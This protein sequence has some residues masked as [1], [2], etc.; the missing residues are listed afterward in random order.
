[1]GVKACLRRL[2]KKWPFLHRL[3]V[4]AYFALRPVRLRELVI[5]TRAREEEWARRHLRGGNDWGN[6]QRA[7]S[8]DEWVMSYWDSRDHAHR[9]FLLGRLSAFHPFSS[10]LEIGCNCGPNLYLVA[11]RF[12][13]AQVWGVDI[14][15]AAVETGTRL[16]ASEGISNVKLSVGRAD[17]LGQFEDNQVDVVFTDAVLIYVGP[18]KIEQVA[19]EMVRVARRGIILVEQHCFGSNWRDRKGLG[20]HNGDVWVRDYSALFQRLAIEAPVR[21]T[22][23]PE[24]AWP[25]GGWR[26]GGIGRSCCSET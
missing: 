12:P 4:R 18:D 13:E 7:G 5:G 20:V 1:M 16:L 6:T 21:I 25:A 2:L 17:D 14:N 26:S 19:R 15:P 11:K 9:P 10:V 24:G 23:L 3:V 8:K 22:K